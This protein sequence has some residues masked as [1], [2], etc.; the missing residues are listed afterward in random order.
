LKILI[1]HAAL[2]HIKGCLLSAN[3][4]VFI[5]SLGQAP[6]DAWSKK[7]P[8]LKARLTESRFQRFVA[9]VIRMPGALPQANLRKA[10]LALEEFEHVA[11][12]SR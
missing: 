10:P 4:A 7:I 12:F 8:A 2:F 6:Q 9:H 5:A 1:S 3:G 11:L